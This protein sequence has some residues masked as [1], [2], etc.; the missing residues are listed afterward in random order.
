MKIAEHKERSF[1]QLLVARATEL[2]SI[3]EK[4]P[5][6]QALADELN[7]TCIAEHAVSRELE[8]LILHLP[9]KHYRIELT[10]SDADPLK[11][12]CRM[13]VNHPFE[14]AISYEDSIEKLLKLFG[15]QDVQVG[16]EQFDKTYLIQGTDDELIADLFTRGE[17]KSILLSNN[18]F[19]FCCRYDPHDHT[20]QLSSLVSRTIHTRE[21]LAEL[22][23]LFSLTIEK[24]EL[25]NVVKL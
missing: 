10:E 11:I 15:Q 23:Q 17:I 3:V 18:V 7:G 1:S 2:K 4:R 21:A 9:F 25:L 24:L 5:F 13:G 22:Y 12:T 20:I 8:R 6:W 19:S 16:D 14:F